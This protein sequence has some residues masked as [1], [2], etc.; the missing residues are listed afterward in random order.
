[1]RQTIKALPSMTKANV[2]ERQFKD[3]SYS[4]ELQIQTLLQ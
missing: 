1:M 2:D 3:K 4:Q